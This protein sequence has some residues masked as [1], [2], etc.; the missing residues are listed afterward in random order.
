M[1]HIQRLDSERDTDAGG[2][3]RQSLP[4]HPHPNQYGGAVTVCCF[5]SRPRCIFP[6]RPTR[7]RQSCIFS[8]RCTNVL[9][10]LQKPDRCGCRAINRGLRGLQW[11]V[12]DWRI[13]Q[14]AMREGG[15]SPSERNVRPIRS[16]RVYSPL[17]SPQPAHL[18]PHSCYA[19]RADYSETVAKKKKKKKNPV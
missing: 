3:R 6:P 18:S 19:R 4:V 12:I 10:F 5:L 11:S 2:K 16:V 17:R 7:L 9:R 15:S 14:V 13:L 1:C 8:R